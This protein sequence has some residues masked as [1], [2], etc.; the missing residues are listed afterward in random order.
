MEGASDRDLVRRYLAGE[1][2]AFD[3][4]VAR[5]ERKVHAVA[6]RM[7]G[8]PEDARD[9]TQE[10]FVSA[11]RSIRGFREEA[12]LGTWFHRIAV[13]ASLDHLRRRRKHA[14]RPIEEVG[15]RPSH[16]PGPDE[17][18]IGASRAAE[19]HRALA[20]LSEE[21]RAVLVLHDL[22]GLD[23]AEVAEALD[24]PVGTVKSRI[25]RGR[26][27]I[28]RMLGHLREG[29]PAAGPGPLKER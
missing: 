18:A 14:P 25:H 6:L 16:D 19:V 9:V 3:D 26:C 22:Q 27:E 23:Y 12:Q 8:D 5:Y 20:R 2:R 28:A 17:L 15:E 29:E 7:C 13:N 10:V 1:A 24:I 21:H 4:L 11:L